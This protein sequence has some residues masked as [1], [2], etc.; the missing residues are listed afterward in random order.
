VEDILY[1]ETKRLIASGILQE[2]CLER[3]ALDG[4]MHQ[5][6]RRGRKRVHA[7]SYER[8]KAYRRRKSVGHPA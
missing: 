7:S 8:L 2:L 3:F 6:P 4:P 5:H 1:R